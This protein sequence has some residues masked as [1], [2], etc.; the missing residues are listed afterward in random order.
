[1]YLRAQQR[2]A[3]SFTLLSSFSWGKSIDNSSSVRNGIGD[4]FTPSNANDH[5]LERGLSGFHFGRR[6]TTSWLFEFPFGKGKRFL[7]SVGRGADLIV[8]GWQLGGIFTL[9][10]G[11]PVTAGCG[12]GNWQNGGGACYPDAVGISPNLPR[13]QQSPDRFF[14]TSAFVNRLPGGPE[15]RFG[16]AAR[17]TIIGPG[18]ISWDASVNKNFRITETARMEFRAEAFNLPNHPIFGPPDT[19]VGGSNYGKITSTAVD[20]RQLQLALKLVF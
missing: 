19:S 9:Q 1:L 15:F 20:S 7:G 11:F 14:N 13:G 18:I 17:N 4:A 12:P 8:G 2:F 6:W 5:S 16:N 10:D 3:H